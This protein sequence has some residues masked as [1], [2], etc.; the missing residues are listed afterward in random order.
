MYQKARVSGA[1]RVTLKRCNNLES[2]FTFII[3]NEYIF[4]SFKD[5]GRTK[6]VPRDGSVKE[7][8][9]YSCIFHAKLKSKK[10]STVVSQ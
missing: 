7:P 3:A 6:P 9:E 4:S 5:D 2:L 8:E 1:V 10:I